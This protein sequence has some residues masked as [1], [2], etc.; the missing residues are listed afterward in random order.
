MIDREEIRRQME[1]RENKELISILLEHDEEQWQP[2]V[3][4]IVGAILAERGVSSGGELKVIRER[5]VH[6]ETEGLSLI[7]VAEYFN[8]LEA[9]TDRITLEGEGIRA[10]VFHESDPLAEGIP[11]GVQLK[12]RQEDW[13]D[14]M[15][16]LGAEMAVSTDLPDDI[17]EP[18]CPRCASRKVTENAEIVED[19]TSEKPSRKQKW[20]YHCANCGLRW[21]E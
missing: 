19:L 13:K 3:F 1:Q 16:R 6:A 11:P 10:W 12:V 18:P 15:E 7:T 20:L 4:D 17:A 8:Y 9:E 14:A 21:S 5:D 2:E